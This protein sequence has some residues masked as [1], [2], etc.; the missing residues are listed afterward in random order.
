ME[1]YK[2]ALNL[3]QTINEG[4]EMMVK[5][6]TPN[7]RSQL[8]TIKKLDQIGGDLGRKLQKDSKVTKKDFRKAINF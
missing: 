4:I 7:Y 6:L 2:T 8:E 1:I 5:G 3:Y